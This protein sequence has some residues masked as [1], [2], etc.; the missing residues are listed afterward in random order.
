MEWEGMENLQ[1]ALK[2]GRGV[3]LMTCHVGNGDIGLSAMSLMG[4]PM[5]LISKEFKARWLNDLWFG[6]RR[7]LGTR[8]IS[9]EKSSFDIL[10]ALKRNEIVVFV[11]DQYMGPP[12]G[13][14]TKFFGRENG[15]S[16]GL[17]FVSG[18]HPRSGLA[19]VHVSP[20]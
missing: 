10:R 13:V 18:T 15:H 2:E 1:N 17:R 14:R 16:G 3:I 12:I 20:A 6:M 4:M 8:F 11:L 19:I 7:R 5:N 9:A